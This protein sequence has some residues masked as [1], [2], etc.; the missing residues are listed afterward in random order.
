MKK[1]LRKIV[2]DQKLGDFRN[3]FKKYNNQ[4]V[5]ITK[6]FVNK[7]KYLISFYNFEINF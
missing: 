5:Y 2:Q 3:Y 4:I 7:V 1:K 6:G